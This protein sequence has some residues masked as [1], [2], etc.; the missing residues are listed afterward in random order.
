MADGGRRQVY[1]WASR[2]VL[3]RVARLPHSL[4]VPLPQPSP[5]RPSIPKAILEPFV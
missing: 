4:C 2:V 1:V 5:N 3:A